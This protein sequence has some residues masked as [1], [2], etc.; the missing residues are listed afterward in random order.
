MSTHS[1]YCRHACSIVGC[2]LVFAGAHA[3]PAAPAH[4]SVTLTPASV[5]AS[6]IQVAPLAESRYARQIRAIATVLDPQP[7]LALAA[8]LQT[9]RAALDA[10]NAQAHAATAE[11]K[12]A[13]ALHRDGDNTSL[14]EAQ[15]AAAAAAAARAKQVAA[16]ADARAERATARAQWG[17]VLAGEAESGSR[18]F[19]AL[20]DGSAALLAVALPPGS[21]APAGRTI[22]IHEENGGVLTATLIGPSSRA[23]PV[24]Q[25]PTY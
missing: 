1:R 19:G 11:A 10:A 7:L 15:A 14:R 21:A 3:A 13:T 18:S 8:Q 16:A 5:T 25:G 9:A 22:H 12:R 6:G 17:A 24:V 23:D 20:A 2:V 4:G